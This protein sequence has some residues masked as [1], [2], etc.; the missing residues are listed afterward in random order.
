MVPDVFRVA[1]SK[2]NS[3]STFHSPEPQLNYQKRID[4]PT[5]FSH[6]RCLKR[7]DILLPANIDLLKI[8]NRNTSKRCEI[9]P[10]LTIKTQERRQLT[11]F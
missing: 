2:S 6:H 9:R 5:A 3:V 8:N 10:K 11:S 4:N 1:K 7:F